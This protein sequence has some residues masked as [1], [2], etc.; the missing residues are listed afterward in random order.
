MLAPLDDRELSC[1]VSPLMSPLCWDLAHIAH[2]EE[3]WLLR[4]LV[5]APP[6]DARFDDLYDA[7]RHPRRERATLDILT[8]P[9]ARQFAEDVRGRVLDVLDRAP[10]PDGPLLHDGFV[11]GM[12]VQH[13]HQHHET[14]LATI[15]LMDRPYGRAPERANRPRA[16]RPTTPRCG[17]RAARWCSAPTMSR[18]RTTTSAPPTESS[19]RPSVSTSPRSPTA[20]TGCSSTRAA[21]T[22]NASGR[23]PGGRGGPRPRLEH[24]QGW[25]REGD[26]VV[27]RAPL[28]PARRPRTRRGGAARLL[29]RGRRVRPLGRQAAPH[30]GR[31]GVRRLVGFRRHQAPLPV[32]RRRPDPSAGE[33]RP[34]CVSARHRSA[35]TPTGRARPG[36]RA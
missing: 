31:V 13:E 16:A 19:W 14:M 21:T 1:Q 6:T 30:R 29:L 24:P 25:H 5:D 2:Y 10:L 22:T 11:Y 17:C 34:R 3:L 18:G 8:P 27:E 4:S 7:F 33:P 28:R 26:G 23:G 36:C 20:P 32:G 35:P 15:G 9:A 12:V